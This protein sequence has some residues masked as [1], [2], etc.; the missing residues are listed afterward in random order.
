MVTTN[1]ALNETF[2]KHWQD[3]VGPVRVVTIVE[4]YV[5]ARR[6]NAMPFLR[7]MD[8]FLRDF[9]PVNRTQP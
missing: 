1:E 9:T 5:V 2:A 3:K 4:G 8:E 6:P 7:K